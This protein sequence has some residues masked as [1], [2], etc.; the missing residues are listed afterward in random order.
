MQLDWCADNCEMSAPG[1]DD[2]E[3]LSTAGCNNTGGPTPPPSGGYYPPP[4]TNPECN[5][6]YDPDCNKPL[7]SADSTT[8]RSGFQKHI[9][10][11]FTDPAK[12]AQCKQLKD[13]FDRLM[14]SGN[15][16]RGAY[17]TPPNDPHTAVHV[18]AYDPASGT[19]HFEPS[20][21]DG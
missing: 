14:A 11:Q 10:T 9:N 21:M 16:Y 2:P 17:D 1:M 13:E 6:Q 4:P 12:A 15:V 18:G 3:H 8:L 5:P 20:A 19:M 7:T